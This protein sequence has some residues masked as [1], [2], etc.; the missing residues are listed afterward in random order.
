MALTTRVRINNRNHSARPVTLQ[1]P[2]VPQGD[3]VSM[4]TPERV[5]GAVDGENG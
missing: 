4:E 3:F 5:Q 2:V 1:Q